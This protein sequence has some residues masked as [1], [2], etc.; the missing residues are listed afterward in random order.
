MLD[1]R[2]DGGADRLGDELLRLI[3]LM[4]R[5]GARFAAQRDDGIERAAYVLLC[6]LVR[7]GP[8]RTGALADAVYSDPSTV[9]R[10]AASLVRHGLVERRP[11]PEDGR[12]SLLAATAEG[13]RAHAAH[14]ALRTAH[15]EAMTR[16]W[17][18]ADRHRLV[19]LLERFN[20]DFAEYDPQLSA[21]HPAEAAR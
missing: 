18:P 1:P 15:L 5:A 11:D 20:T 7:E 14:R 8:Q 4:E 19:A 6:H 9:S 10:Q 2:A 13:R 21:L 3:R 12:A 16:H 17:E